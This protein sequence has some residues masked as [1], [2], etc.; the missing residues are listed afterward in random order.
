MAIPNQ[1]KALFLLHH[2]GP[3][4]VETTPVHTLEPGEVLV[5]VDAT[6]LN[7]S[8]WKTRFTEYS[9][10]HKEYPAVQGHDV[11][12]TVVQVSQGVTEFAVGD[13]V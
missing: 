2:A 1:Q 12:G 3:Y 7:P 4:S 11:A 10:V 9:A 5:R 13:R 8:D 6:D